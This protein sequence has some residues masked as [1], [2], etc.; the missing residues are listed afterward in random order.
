MLVR[1]F[2]RSVCDARTDASAHGSFYPA[3]RGRPAVIQVKVN[4][5]AYA[6]VAS[7]KVLRIFAKHGVPTRM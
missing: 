5:Q 1:N 3:Y 2:S 7:A 6:T 4:G